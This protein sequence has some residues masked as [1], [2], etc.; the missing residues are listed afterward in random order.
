HRL[1]GGVFSILYGYDGR[2][3]S[4]VEDSQTNSR[5]KKALRQM[6]P[7]AARRDHIIGLAVLNGRP[8]ASTDLG[9]DKRFPANRNVHNR[10]AGFKAGVAVP[11][12][13]AGSVIG[14]IGV[15]RMEAKAFSRAEVSL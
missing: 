6:Y 11:L 14:A 3:L 8:V 2:L 4:I 1:C 12:L 9:A 15:A 5:G 13:H 10:T 7:A